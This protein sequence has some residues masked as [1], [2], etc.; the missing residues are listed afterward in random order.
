[1]GKILLACFK[2]MVPQ[3][4][5]AGFEQRKRDQARD[6]NY[7]QARQNITRFLQSTQNATNASETQHPAPPHRKWA[8]VG[9]NKTVVPADAQAQHRAAALHHLHLRCRG[10]KIRL[11]SR[12]PSTSA[13]GIAAGGANPTDENIV[14]GSTCGGSTP[15]AAFALT[16]PRTI[17]SL[18]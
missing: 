2:G 1:M 3:L 13:A 9:H 7:R 4:H 16:S 8:D 10:F 15:S 17:G 6:A 5:I 18:A 11:P 14:I 12:R